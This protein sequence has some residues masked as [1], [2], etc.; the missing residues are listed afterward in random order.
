MAKTNS[1]N[2]RASV[3]LC[4]LL[5]E[6]SVILMAHQ[7]YWQ[8]RQSRHDDPLLLKSMVDMIA[9]QLDHNIKLIDELNQGTPATDFA[10]HKHMITSAVANTTPRNWYFRIIQLLVAAAIVIYLMGHGH[11]VVYVMLAL[12]A[13]VVASYWRQQQQYLEQRAKIRCLLLVEC[14]EQNAGT[15]GEIMVHKAWLLRRLPQFVPFRFRT[16]YQT[17]LAEALAPTGDYSE[18]KRKLER[19]YTYFY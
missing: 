1:K 3:R 12:A 9:C 2:N 19:F 4:K 17:T 10:I 7:D 15:P 11:W 6:S 8:Y 18:S 5:A 14:I 16:V 13:A